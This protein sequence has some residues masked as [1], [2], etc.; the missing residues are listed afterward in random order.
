MLRQPR[1]IGTIHAMAKELYGALIEDGASDWQIF[2]RNAT[3]TGEINLRGRW[4]HPEPGHVEV[5]LVGEATGAT[6][7]DWQR[8][9]TRPDG[10]WSVQIVGIPAGGL[11]RLETRYRPQNWLDG[12]WAPRGD[13]RHFLGVGDLWVIAGQSNCAGYGRGPYND[14]PTLGVHLFRNSET[15]ALATH[16]MNESTGI[17][18]GRP[19]E[20]AN[21]GHSPC[22]HFGRLLQQALG[23]P[24]GLV[25]T[26]LGG[27][28]LSRWNP[29]EPGESDLCEHMLRCVAAVGGK[30][31]G[32]LWYQGESET[33]N[34][35]TATTSGDRFIA[36]VQAWRKQLQ[37]PALPV[38]TVQLNRLY[39][40]T[41]PNADRAWSLVREA[42]RRVPQ[43]LPGVTVVP[44]LDLPLCDL[45]HTSAAGNLLLGERLA[46]AALG[47]PSAPDIQSARRT[48]TGIEL[49]F[50]PVTSRIDNMDQTAKPFRVE[51]AEGE[52]PIRQVV[53]PKNDTVQ[54]VL[55]RPLAGNAVVHAGYGA[56]PPLMPMDM[57]RQL[58]VLAFSGLPV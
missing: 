6:V 1:D 7:R 48:A 12:E 56:N 34:L 14:P 9:E 29:T 37:A 57:E 10:T 11:Y 30:V 50:A 32:I 31:A 53:Y 52:V 36:A 51:D 17:R 19:L 42:Q 40:A 16:P 49:R 8:A 4:L 46:R 28:P 39:N 58:P 41:D 24:I 45:V 18:P 54:L 47:G 3:G 55:E 38:L 20:D 43:R 13:M 27:S 26:A 23:C 35:A 33:G 5:R 2:Q 21:P 22:L 44:S 25:Q 15:W